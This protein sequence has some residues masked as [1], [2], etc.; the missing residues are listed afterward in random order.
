MFLCGENE[1][2]VDANALVWEAVYWGIWQKI[3]ETQDVFGGKQRE[4]LI[5]QGSQDRKRPLV[6]PKYQRKPKE[7]RNNFMMTERT[8]LHSSPLTHKEQRSGKVKWFFKTIQAGPSPANLSS[9]LPAQGFP[10]YST[11][12]SQIQL[13]VFF[14]ACHD[15]FLERNFI[16]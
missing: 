9:L 13:S 3:P 5:T 16:T 12:P 11:L 4:E 10:H 15:F 14:S 7:M 1:S 2:Q 6:F 8:F